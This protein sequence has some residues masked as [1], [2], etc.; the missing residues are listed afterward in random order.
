MLMRLVNF[1][2]LELRL[3]KRCYIPQNALVPSAQI[4]RVINFELFHNVIWSYGCVV[5]FT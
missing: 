2:S 5:S 1:P 3:T 4:V